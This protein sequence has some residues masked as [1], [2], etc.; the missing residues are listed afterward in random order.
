LIAVL[1]ADSIGK[2]FGT[3]K[4]LTSAFFEARLGEAVGLIGRNG[5]GKSTLLKIAAGWLSADHG[6]V[7]FLGTRY[8]RPPAAKLAQAG[9]LYLP[10]DRSVLSPVFT[11]GQHLDALRQRFGPI[12]RQPVLEELGIAHLQLHVTSALSGG[13]R[14]RAELAFASLRRPQCLLV[15]EPFRGIDPKDAEVVAGLLRRMAGDGCAVAFTGH[16]V[17]WMLEAAER[18]VW[19]RNGTTELLGTTTEAAAHWQFRRDYLGSR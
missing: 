2:S 17:H 8:V 3:R 11:L 7:E 9:L 13:E 15:D 5:A 12:D 1:R 4:V 19:I 14:R 16:E 10:V 18:V 6:I